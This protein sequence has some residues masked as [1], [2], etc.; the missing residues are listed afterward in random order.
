M[1]IYKQASI[2]EIHRRIGLEIPK[3]KVRSEL[4]YLVTTGEIQQQGA[5][6][7]TQYLWTKEA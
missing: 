1:E 3:R 2:G 7:W 6:K 5:N 4:Q